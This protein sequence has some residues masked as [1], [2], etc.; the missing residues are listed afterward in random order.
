MARFAVILFTVLATAALVSVLESFI[1]FAPL[2][3]FGAPIATA[4]YVADRSGALVAVATAAVIGDFLF[5]EPRGD[6][7][8]RLGE[9]SAVRATGSLVR[10]S[11]PVSGSSA[12]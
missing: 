6:A 9:R 3:L 4:L 5:V 12:S 11:T 10:L 1:W 7:A 8:Q 2:I